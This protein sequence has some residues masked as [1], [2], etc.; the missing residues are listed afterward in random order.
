MTTGRQRSAELRRT[1]L[2]RIYGRDGKLL[3]VG[4]AFDPEERWK[5][6]HRAPWWPLVNPRLTKVEWFRSREGAEIAE[7]RAIRDEK[8]IYNKAP[9]TRLRAYTHEPRRWPTRMEWCHLYPPAK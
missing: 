4:V 7:E 8:P 2:Y 1:A 9:R 5:S 3:Y 6:H